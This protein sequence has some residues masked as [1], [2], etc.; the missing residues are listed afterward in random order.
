MIV[1]NSPIVG[2]VDFAFTLARM[3]EARDLHLHES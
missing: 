1:R 2:L 3:P